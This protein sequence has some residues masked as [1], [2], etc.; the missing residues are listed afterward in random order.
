MLTQEIAGEVKVWASAQDQQIGVWASATHEP[1]VATGSRSRPD[2]PC[3]WIA[4]AASARTTVSRSRGADSWCLPTLRRLRS[5]VALL[6][7]KA[8]P[9]PRTVSNWA[10]T[11]RGGE[12]VATH[13]VLV[14]YTDQG[15]RNVKDSPKRADA[16]TGL[17]D[18]AGVRIRDIYW[19]SGAHDGVLV[20]EAPDDAAVSRLMLSVGRLGNVRTQTL[21]AFDRSE[22]EAIV[23]GVE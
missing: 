12:T 3:A 8:S 18:K 17:A 16:L 23:G 14:D 4:L 13:I 22:F 11:Q 15:I 5:I 19:T 2:M 20:L 7:V 9:G 21:R 1:L 6:H 10:F